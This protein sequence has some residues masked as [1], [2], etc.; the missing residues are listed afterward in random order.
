MSDPNKRL[1]VCESFLTCDQDIKDTL[2]LPC[3]KKRCLRESTYEFVKAV[4]EEY[5][6]EKQQNQSKMLSQIQLNA[7]NGKYMVNGK[8]FCRQGLIHLF[9]TSGKRLSSIK[10]KTNQGVVNFE[11]SNK[12]GSKT[13]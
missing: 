5:A 12:G 10:K 13:K 8:I 11:K 6:G 7:T 1:G 3:C 9:H 2:T 4:R